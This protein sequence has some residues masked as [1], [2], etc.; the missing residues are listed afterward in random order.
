M[1]GNGLWNV[2]AAA[3][4]YLVSSNQAGAQDQTLNKIFISSLQ[5]YGP[6]VFPLKQSI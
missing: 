4:S 5:Y 3:D 6:H 1:V 2:N